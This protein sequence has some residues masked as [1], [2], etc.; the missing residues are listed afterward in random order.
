[1]TDKKDT[2]NFVKGL[3]IRT[4]KTKYGEILNCGIKL[5]DLIA[6]E[7]KFTPEGWLN[8]TIKKGKSGNWY[9]EMRE[10]KNAQAEC[11]TGAN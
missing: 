9:A 4:V 1:M 6:D 2:K 8:F 11:E 5:E 10:N 3:S 7:S